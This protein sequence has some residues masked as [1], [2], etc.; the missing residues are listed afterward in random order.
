MATDRSGGRICTAIFVRYAPGEPL[1]QR[2]MSAPGTFRP[3]SVGSRWADSLP[4]NCAEPDRKRPI[5]VGPFK[6]LGVDTVAH[7]QPINTILARTSTLVT[8]DAQHGQLANDV[9]ED[10]GAIAGHHKCGVP[11]YRA[12]GPTTRSQPIARAGI[13]GTCTTSAAHGARTCRK[14]SNVWRATG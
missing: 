2:L 7:N 3:L 10:D 14:L 4:L 1:A 6:Q 11:A 9:A 5:L 12:T 8:N 13:Q